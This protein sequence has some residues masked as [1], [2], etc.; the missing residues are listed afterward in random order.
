MLRKS[1]TFVVIFFILSVAIFTAFRL[2]KAM[3]TDRT[4][5][6]IEMDSDAIT[7]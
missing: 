4:I 5:P 1:R 2:T 3:T 6:I 7:V